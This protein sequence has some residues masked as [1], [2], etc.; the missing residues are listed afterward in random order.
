MRTAQAGLACALA[1]ALPA[2]VPIAAAA[3]SPGAP[4]AA[5]GRLRP[6]PAVTCDRNH[7]TAW[8]GV[9]TG[10]RRKAASTWLRIATDEDTVESTTVAHAGA[11]DASAR[12]LLRGE[13]LGRGDL[14]RIEASKRKLQPGMRATAWICD[15]GRTPPVID[16]QPPAR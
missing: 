1:L 2:L 10:Y 7:L 12:F 13:P 15:D 4:D 5:P 6:V 16:W 8:T 9:V 14:A 3:A 11:P